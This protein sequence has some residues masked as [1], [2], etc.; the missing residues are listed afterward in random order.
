MSQSVPMSTSF[1]VLLWGLPSGDFPVCPEPPDAWSHQQPPP[2]TP[3][4][5]CYVKRP[6]GITEQ[7]GMG[8][9]LRAVYGVM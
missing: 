8:L 4:M 7:D 6:R 9:G 5:F 2:P 3:S 1:L